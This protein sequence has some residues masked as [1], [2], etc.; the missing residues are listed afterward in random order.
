MLSIIATKGGKQWWTLAYQIVGT[1]V[2]NHIK[3]LVE[4]TD[5]TIPPWD[6]LMPQF[7]PDAG[8]NV[9]Q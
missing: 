7:N 6:V 4:E 9:A 2:G 8:D 1:D 5:G 3:K